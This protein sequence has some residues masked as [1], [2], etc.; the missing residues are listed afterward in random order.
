MSHKV[1]FIGNATIS[2]DSFDLNYKDEESASDSDDDIEYDGDPIDLLKL[3]DVKIKR[4]AQQHLPRVDLPNLKPFQIMF[5]DNKEFPCEQ[6]DGYKTAFVCIDVKTQKK[7]VCKLKRKLHNELAM[8][9]IIA[10]QGIHKLPYPCRLYTDGCGSMK[11]VRELVLKMGLGHTYVP[12]HKQS[13]NDAEK[14]VDRVWA[15]AKTHTMHTNSPMKFFADCCEYVVYIDQYM[16][17]N[18]ARDNLSPL[19]LESGKQPSILHLVPW[20]TE[21]VV[22]APKQ[23]RA[24]LKKQ[25]DYT[26][27]GEKGNFIGYESMESKVYK[28]ALSGNR[29][30]HSADVVFDFEGSRPEHLPSPES[31]SKSLAELEIVFPSQQS[32]DTNEEANEATLEESKEVNDTLEEAKEAIPKEVSSGLQDITE[33]AKKVV[34]D[35]PWKTH[36]DAPLKPRPRPNYDPNEVR[37]KVINLVQELDDS[38]LRGSMKDSKL[39][40]AISEVN[41]D[42]ALLN[43]VSHYLA[44]NVSRKD[45]SWKE[46][47]NGPLKDKAIIALNNEIES[48]TK[49][50][51]RPLNQNDSVYEKAVKEATS[52]RYILDTKRNGTVKARGV[53][54]GFEENIAITDGPDFNYYA[55]VAEVKAVRAL[56]LRPD[57]RDR[58]LALKDVRTAFLQSVPYPDGKKKYVKFKH[59]VTG[60]WTWFEQSG[61]TCGENSAPVFW[62]EETLAPFLSDFEKCGLIRGENHKCVYY[63]S[64]KDLNLLT[65]VDDFMLD[66]EEKDVR[67]IDVVIDGRFDCKPLE[68]LTIDE[69]VEFI[70]IEIIMTID[71]IYLSMEGYIEKMVKELTEMGMVISKREASTPMNK[72]IN[73]DGDSPSLTPKQTRLLLTAHGCV[74]WCAHTTRIDASHGFSRT[75]Q[76]SA[77]PTE[78]SLE[79]VTH[80]VNYLWY[81][82]DL[83]LYQSRYIEDTN[84]GDTPENYNLLDD[85]LGFRVYCDTDHAGNAEIQNKRRSQNGHVLMHGEAVVDYYSKASSVGFATPLIGEAHA[86]MNTGAV[87]VYGT[88]NATLETLNTAYMYEELGIPFP[89]PFELLVDNT[90]AKA[91][92]DETVKRS[93]LKYI[94]C[95]QE[96]CKMIRNKKICKVIHC[97]TKINNSDILTKILAPGEF[98]GLRNKMMISHPRPM[99]RM[100]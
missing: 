52:G 46:A 27:T 10:Q 60:E 12:P 51:L 90:T 54:R 74:G 84:F 31:N 4:L 26:S 17:T 92:C 94:D 15:S 97:K 98:I 80:M 33:K 93:K 91:F 61:P 95:R 62:G 76:H 99:K 87:E 13:L 9:E 50:I 45:I 71:R 96:W 85:Q 28:I 100:D 37:A 6:R 58:M 42:V 7:F 32:V 19:E 2:L 67:W 40:E 56:C 72:P 25:G 39:Y 21:C 3:E 8:A 20:W 35:A 66:G 41:G 86:D 14:V 73:V 77:N 36:D 53:K 64:E 79:A 48:L 38:Q 88:A 29:I 47:L 23:K 68:I 5:A 83:C 69:S 44:M 75:G 81:N 24:W 18:A 70:G 30:V 16:S 82:K 55:H 11:P 65:Y 63:N 34:G 59:P 57:R 78:D 89:F 1:A 22:V 49:T 43:E